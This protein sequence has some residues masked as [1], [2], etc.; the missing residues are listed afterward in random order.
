MKKWQVSELETQVLGRGSLKGLFCYSFSSGDC[1]GHMTFP[2]L[3]LMLRVSFKEGLG[4]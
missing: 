4:L 1:Q 2:A 3:V